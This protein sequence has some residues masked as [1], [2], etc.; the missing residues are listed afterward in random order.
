MSF[1]KILVVDDEVAICKLVEHRLRKQ[2]HVVSTA[3]R[4]GEA[5]SLLER[6]CFDLVL[7]DFHLPDGD[8]LEFLKRAMEGPAS[9]VMVMVSACTSLEIAI[10]CIRTGAFDYLLK[11]FSL[12]ELDSVVRRAIVHR[13]DIHSVRATTRPQHDVR[14]ILGESPCIQHLRTM[15]QKVAPTDVPVLITGESGVGKGRVSQALHNASA[16]AAG[17]LLRVNCSAGNEAEIENELFG[18][19]SPDEKSGC[20][21]FARG[22]TIVLEEISELPLRLQAKL[23]EVLQEKS[24]ERAGCNKPVEVDARFIATTCRDL[25][26][27]LFDGSFRQDLLFHLN[28]FPLEV[29]PLR[30]RISDLP[31]LVSDWL[32]KL[33]FRNGLKPGGISD[34]A[35]KLMMAYCWPGNVRELETVLERAAV[36]AGFGERIEA[37]AFLHLGA[38]Q[39]RL[40][41]HAPAGSSSA[42]ESVVLGPIVESSGDRLLTL[43]ELEK[44][45]VLRALEHT[46]QNRTRAANLLKISVR[47]L[48]NKLHQYRAESSLPSAARNNELPLISPSA[49]QKRNIVTSAIGGGNGL[50]D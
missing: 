13:E 22:G 19:G 6:E 40:L 30:E 24:F 44:Q 1:A 7:L 11:P 39:A 26:Q 18:F 23:M 34:E 16:R 17:P 45:H 29:P 10:Q 41:A 3:G 15:L 8:G 25:S 5:V 32:E 20:M 27:A 43:D 49:G 38:G 31:L 14:E 46:N 9:P 21:E 35:L 4:L 36:L 2:G 48:R 28:V 33:A 12:G 37:D 50:K 42:H 47:T